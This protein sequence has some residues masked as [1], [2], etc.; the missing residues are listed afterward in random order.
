MFKAKFTEQEI[1]EK[2]KARKF[3]VPYNNN[4]PE[5]Y[6]KK[7]ID[8]HLENIDSVYFEVP[9]ILIRNHMSFNITRNVQ[10]FFKSQQYTFKFV[11]IL[12]DTPKYANIK[13]YVTLNCASYTQLSQY[14][15]YLYVGNYMSELVNKYKI[16]GIICADLEFA[17]AV[18][19]IFP[20]L[21]IQTS[22]N[23]Y[24][25]LPRA[26]TLWHN[27]VGT[28]TFNPPR[29]VMRDVELLKK[30]ASTGFR[31]KCLVNEACVFG[32]PQN[33]NHAHYVADKGLG[34]ELYCDAYQPRLSDIFRTNFVLPRHL[35]YYDDYVDLYKL[36][37]RGH[38]TDR[39]AR[40][41]DAYVNERDDVPLNHAITSRKSKLLN[42]LEAEYNFTIPVSAVPDK[43]LTCMC[44]KCDNG[45]EICDKI[46]AKL[47]KKAGLTE[48]QLEQ[49]KLKC[50]PAYTETD[51][52]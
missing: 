44:E 33:I 41:V 28:T 30:I 1:I 18:K 39:I 25:F 50:D 20:Q 38:K 4:E 21:D 10:E 37:G 31:L 40:I 36:S 2:R 16:D 42:T 22:C 12:R 43:L 14:D 24:Q 35:K 48:E 8:P 19:A 26:M 46:I 29:E 49:V 45:C 9:N 52:I 13:K 17:A 7:V 11:Q 5:Y 23:T 32:C 27:A 47:M 6:L 15:K 34:H 3:T 51:T